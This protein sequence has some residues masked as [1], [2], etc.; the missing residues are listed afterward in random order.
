LSTTYNYHHGH[1][2]GEEREFRGFGMVEQFDTEVFDDYHDLSLFRSELDFIS[3]DK[4]C[5]SPPTL[6][7][8][9]FHLGPIRKN[10]GEWQTADFSDEYSS[11][12]EELL[13]STP[14]TNTALS[15]LRH[16][17]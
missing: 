11:R 4:K 6:T 10:N 1:W 14:Y 7:K 9:W 16:E 17:Q 2:D 3:V 8:T 5:F 15:S 12:D 13:N